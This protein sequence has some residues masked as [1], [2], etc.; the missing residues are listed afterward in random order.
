[1]S[2]PLDPGDRID[3]S[4]SYFHRGKEEAWIKLG[5]SVTVRDGET[6]EEARY[7]LTDFINDQMPGAIEEVVSS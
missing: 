4:V 7:R 6:A 1:M 2:E 3:Y 5:A